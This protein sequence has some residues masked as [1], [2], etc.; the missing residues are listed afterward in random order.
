MS[1]VG[2]CHLAG[3]VLEVLNTALQQRAG[4]LV[5]LEE[6]VRGVCGSQGESEEL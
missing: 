4:E 1:E 5:L 3:A 6:V 2:G